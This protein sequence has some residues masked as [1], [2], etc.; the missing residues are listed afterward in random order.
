M[1]YQM[2]LISG[3]SYTALL[4]NCLEIGGD[5]GDRERVVQTKRK[6]AWK[7]EEKE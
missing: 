5:C 1:L 4:N 3:I 6:T 2:S 7:D